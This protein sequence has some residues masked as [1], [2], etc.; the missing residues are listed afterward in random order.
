PEYMVPTAFVT[1]DALP[2]T[3]NGKLDRKALPAPG[4]G[5]SG[6]SRAPRTSR[7]ELLCALF[8]QVLGLARVGIDDSFFD[9]GGDS[10]IA[11][12]LV[13]L[14][15]RAG[16]G[17]TVREVFA[18]RTVG[19][20]GKHIAMAAAEPEV[21]PALKAPLPD[22]E[23]ER[24]ADG[25]PGVV[26]VLPLSPLQEGL[27][28]HSVFDGHTPDV[29]TLQVT[30]E[31]EGV[32]DAHALR[33]AA[34]ELLVRHPALRS[35]FPL[36][37]SGR[38]VQAVAGAAEPVWSERE[39]YAPLDTEAAEGVAGENHGLDVL[40]TNERNRKF[41]LE[42]P[43]LIRFLLVRTGPDRACVTVTAHHAVLDGWSLPLVLRELLTL[44]RGGAVLPPVRPYRDHLAWLAGRDWQ[45]SDVAWAE[46]LDGLTEPSVLV[47]ADPGRVP[48]EPER[49]EFGLCAADTRELG[50]RARTLG[51]TLNTVTQAAWGIVLSRLLGRTD[52]VFGV[53]VSGRPPEL[54]GVEDMVGLFINTLPLRLAL[55]PRETLADV[56][57]RLQAEQTRLLDHQHLG[58]AR[59]QRAA[60]LGDL[61]DTSL[62]YEN[63]PLDS[64]EL[65]ALADQAGLR[66]A[67]ARSRSALPYTYGLVALPGDALRF[68]LDFQPDL[69]D[70][71]DA[72]AVAARLVRVLK[73]VLADPALPVGRVDVLSA[74]ERAQA[75]TGGHGPVREVAPVA[76]PQ[77][78][79]AQAVRTPEAPAVHDGEVTLTY[80]ELNTC[81]NR[82]ARLLAERG[83]GPERSVAVLLP[84]SAELVVT[85]L[86]VA[87]S[88][89]E[90]VPVDPGY[91]A[92]RIQ[93]TLAATDAVAVVDQHWPG[94]AD[95]SAYADG[96]L[97][98]VL[99]GT[100]AYTI[101]TSGST[102]LPKGVVVEHRSLSDYL[103]RAREVYE[104]ATGVSL[105][106]SSVS[107]DLT[108]TALWAPLVSGGAV[109]IGDLDE[110]VAARGPRPTLVKVTP[111]H[112]G[113]LEVM[114]AG[115]SP[116]GTLLVAG[117]A[118]RGEVL[119]R[120][121]TAHPDVRI[122]NAYGPTET[123]VTAAE[124]HV[125]P[126]TPIAD[127][128]VPIGRPF[129]NTRTYV[130]DAG[131]QPVPAGAPGELYIAGA[132]LARGYLDR[133]GQTAERFVADP[134]GPP[135]TRM[136]RTGDL[137]RRA[138]DD[139]LEYLGRID[140]QV[141]V[142]GFRIELG[143]I[144]AALL[145]GPET[146]RA[147]VLVR[148]DRPG[149][150]RLVGYVV[151]ADGMR[152]RPD[153]LRATA[154][155]LLPEYMVP[156]AVVVLDALPLTP[157][158]KLDR[159]A[160]PAPDFSATASRAP[161]TALEA[162][163]CG[164]IAEVLDLEQIGVDD[165]FFD[166]GGD[167]IMSIQVVS[168][169]RRAGW[170]ITPRD[171]FECKTAAR[172]A[173]VAVLSAADPRPEAPCDA[174]GAVPLTPIMRELA[175]RQVP[176][177]QYSQSTSIRVP[178]LV[179]Y[180]SLTGALQAVLDR[181]D[182]LRMRVTGD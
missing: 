85:L 177:A 112:L 97:P 23:L 164:L 103:A 26:D 94:R 13:G 106:H 98:P 132:P 9:L 149:D 117:E 72:E 90:Y 76:L 61:F 24:L 33:A 95:L 181:H 101:F 21:A 176:F 128:P 10:I 35:A 73:A 133:P 120:W 168:A 2:L 160:L 30:V 166:L 155:R 157:N 54:D 18:H 16:L 127:G 151:P 36:S 147:A 146:V 92:E 180:E 119:R 154:A 40:L 44:Y 161:A 139:T 42:R 138:A 99:P 115:V 165:S 178:A 145:S 34:A 108:V 118:L 74:A 51:V 43:E 158:G 143:E 140:Q 110:D 41:D 83:A 14:A 6:F 29:Y 64:A 148:E 67:D 134:Y 4:I 79:E 60:G 52:V 156:A 58:L 56:L 159:A 65:H 137:V 136:Y 89:A 122:V 50:E 123:T 114:P 111:S 12:R 15:R 179:T 88:G 173:E 141:K 96:N 11:I 153:E 78:F 25:L 66:L 152:P 48:V 63:Y 37:E 104:D 8:A 27:V 171:V 69:V 77:L 124:H 162:L 47:A 7:E 49:V 130:L 80:R 55:N 39:A 175:L 46:A 144:E 62:V 28:F 82:L 121:R 167:S 172:L 109:R 84:R 169:A 100:P 87:K 150:R 20:L 182:A 22:D 3:P 131:L 71:A 163:L 113:L 91:P 75:L 125:A 32:L 57:G 86:A 105:L 142:R 81:A 126:G 53:T 174:T 116:T 107:F 59:I 70:R 31:F 129:W 17:L 170:Q 135:G 93:R 19:A 1:L 102:G 68:R 45:A 38:P 5:A